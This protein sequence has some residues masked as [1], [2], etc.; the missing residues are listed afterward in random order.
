MLIIGDVKLLASSAFIILILIFDYNIYQLVNVYVQTFTCV[1]LHSANLCLSLCYS[2]AI[3]FTLKPFFLSLSLSLSLSL[4]LAI[5]Y[6]LFSSRK[7]LFVGTAGTIIS[8][9]LNSLKTLKE[10]GT[11]WA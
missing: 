3:I 11:D 8:L 7:S 1:L 6:P 4:L 2:R 10:S 5:F 9:I